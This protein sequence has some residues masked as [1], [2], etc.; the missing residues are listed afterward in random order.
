MTRFR[1]TLFDQASRNELGHFDTLAEA[2]EAL[3]RFLAHAPEAADDLQI[4]DE[5]EDVRVEVD[6]AKLRPA[7]AA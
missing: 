2:E 3:T 5:D 1:Y 6:P 4:W 7:P